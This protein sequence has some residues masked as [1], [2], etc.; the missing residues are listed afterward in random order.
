MERHGGSQHLGIVFGADDHH[1]VFVFV[2]ERWGKFAKAESSATCPACGGGDASLVCAIDHF[3]EAWHAMR[4]SM[5]AQL[6]TD[7]ATTHLV[8]HCR[9]R[10]AT[11]EAIQHKVA[12]RSCTLDNPM[13]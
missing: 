6:N 11:E 9:R 12:R 5:V 10:T 3:L 13:Y 8:C 1:S 4:I 2:E 7:V